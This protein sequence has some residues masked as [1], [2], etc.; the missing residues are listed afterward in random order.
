MRGEIHEDV[1]GVLADEGGEL[2][3]VE[4]GET[5]RGRRNEKRLLFL[6]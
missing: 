2:L 4:P 1:D 6:S 5:L 3:V